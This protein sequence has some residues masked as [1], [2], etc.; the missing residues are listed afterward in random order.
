MLEI[1]PHLQ[2]APASMP[3]QMVSKR[4]KNE[5]WKRKTMDFLE[6]EGIRQIAENQ[7]YYENYRLVNGEFIEQYYTNED[8]SASAWDPIIQFSEKFHLPKHVRHYDILS[9]PFLSLVGEFINLPD[10]AFVKAQGDDVIASK[11]RIKKQLITDLVMQLIDKDLDAELVRRGMEDPNLIQFNSEEERT[12]YLQQIEAEKQKLFPQEYKDFDAKWSHIAEKWAN[13]QIKNNILEYNLRRLNE[14]DFKHALI[15]AKCFR[16]F[17]LT[18]NGRTEECW[19][20][21]TV[22][23]S[24]GFNQEYPEDGAFIGR[25]TPMNAEDIINTFGFQLTEEQL[26]GLE[27]LT[28]KVDLKGTKDAMGNPVNYTSIEGTPYNVVLPYLNPEFDKLP[29]VGQS[30]A[31]SHSIFSLFR[32][33]KEGTALLNKQYWVTEVYWF[34]QERIGKVQFIDEE[35]G[36]LVKRIVDEDFIVPPGFEEI[37]TSFNDTEYDETPNVVIWTLT[38]ELWE[39][40]KI[41]GTRGDNGASGP[42]YFGVQRSPF[43]IKAAGKIWDKKL[44]VVGLVLDNLTV[45]PQ[46]FV[47]RAKP[48]QIFYNVIM[49]HAYTVYENQIMPFVVMDPNLIPNTGDWGFR[50]MEKWME[51]GQALGAT[52]A[53]THPNATGGAPVQGGAFPRVIDVNTTQH[54]IVYL[55]LAAAVRD[56]ALQQIGFTPQRLGNVGKSESATGVQG[57]V[58]GS[59]NQTSTYFSAFEDY[60]RRC[61]QMG[62]NFDQFI[63]SEN[64]ELTVQGIHSDVSNQFFKLNGIDLLL[65]DLHVYIAN[66]KNEAQKLQILKQFML[67]NNT[68]LTSLKS[69]VD[70]LTADTSTV[71]M[72]AA[73]VADEELR[74]QNERSMQLQEQQLQMQQQQFDEA[75]K[76]EMARFNSKLENDLLIAYMNALPPQQGTDDIEFKQTVELAKLRIQE[77]NMDNQNDLNRRKLESEERNAG[78]N[79]ARLNNQDRIA[80]EREKTERIKQAE[81]TRRQILRD[82]QAAKLQR[83]K[84]VKK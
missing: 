80:L 8:S 67:E 11:E 62:L 78:T 36:Q 14:N 49:N 72:H 84:Q 12:Q 82:Q 46:S 56:L 44:P 1:N 68:I 81:L 19:H 83:A 63:Q 38:N 15:T 29:T 58:E 60:Q 71:I 20:P 13:V 18:P 23:L 66:A 16:H 39:G 2:G 53:D 50:S 74:Q 32:D 31:T 9:Q 52:V 37:K 57:A 55:N 64:D 4:K 51:V 69:R 26:R 7:R 76:A 35:T 34:A 45:A 61:H 40:K 77:R 5:K 79:Q 41:S 17:K 6:R 27:S 21:M 48:F 54:L 24:K 43:Q 33:S 10:T 75:Q 28:S 59:Y 25:G 65:A 42:I 70:I 47:D 30:T 3:S 22:F 73:K